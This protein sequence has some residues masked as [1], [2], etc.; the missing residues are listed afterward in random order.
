MFFSNFIENLAQC[1]D[2]Q[3][4]S[5]LVVF[6][7]L[8]SSSIVSMVV[9]I[10]KPIFFLSSQ[11]YAQGE[12]EPPAPPPAEGELVGRGRQKGAPGPFS[13][14]GTVCHDMFVSW[15]L[16]R[17]HGLQSLDVMQGDWCS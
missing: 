3:V 17:N 11:S 13:A 2:L 4:R 7:F 15:S 9:H 12:P 10:M 6:I 14:E 5:I 8:S 1:S 16:S